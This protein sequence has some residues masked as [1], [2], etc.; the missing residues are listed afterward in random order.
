MIPVAYWE[1]VQ[2]ILSMFKYA[3]TKIAF[4]AKPILKEASTDTVD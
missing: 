4:C 2:M 3:S 1:M